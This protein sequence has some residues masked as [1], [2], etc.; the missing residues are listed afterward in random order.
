VAGGAQMIG[1]TRGRNNGLYILHIMGPYGNRQL[2]R[3]K[4]RIMV[5]VVRICRGERRALSLEDI[6]FRLFP[7]SASK[8][9]LA[10]V[11]VALAAL[12]MPG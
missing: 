6:L 5:V 7:T 10:V 1:P 12:I 2:R 3:D 11:M 9:M 8:I 4:R